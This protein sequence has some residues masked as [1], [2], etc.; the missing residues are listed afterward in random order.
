MIKRL[1][2]LNFVKVFECSARHL[3]LHRAA[4]ELGVTPG[5][6]SQQIRALETISTCH[7]LSGCT[8]SY[9]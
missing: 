4:E 8:K 2:P 7:F 1:P 3:N 9:G 5:A 6:V